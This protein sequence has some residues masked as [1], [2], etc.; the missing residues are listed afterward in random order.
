MSSLKYIGL[1]N[2][3]DIYVT[4][5]LGNK[6]VMSRGEKKYINPQNLIDVDWQKGNYNLIVDYLKDAPRYLEYRGY[7]ECRLCGVING[8]C[9]L[10]DGEWAWPSGLYHYCEVHNIILPDE[11]IKT[12]IKNKFEVPSKFVKII[13]RDGFEFAQANFEISESYLD[14]SFWIEWCGIRTRDIL[15]S[16]GLI[17]ST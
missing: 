1:W 5:A 10:T 13:N 14:D 17:K 6:Y 16:E 8:S 11:F 7:S 3:D 4:S 15:T 2:S 9:D 12:M